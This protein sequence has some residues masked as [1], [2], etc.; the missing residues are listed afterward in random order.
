MNIACADTEGGGGRV[1]T[2]NGK[3]Q[4]YTGFV[5]NTGPGPLKDHKATIIGTPAERH[6]ADGPMM[7]CLQ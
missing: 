3:S 2:P 5:S 1:P 7:T 4:I 6:F